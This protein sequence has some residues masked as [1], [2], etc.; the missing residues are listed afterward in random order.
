MNKAKIAVVGG[1]VAGSTAALYL[2]EIG[3]NVTLFEKGRSLI[4]G[5][6]FCHLHAGGNLY[7][8]I[9][10]EQCITLLGQSIDLLR[11][12]PYSVDFRPTVIAVPVEDSSTPQALFPRLEKLK[13]AYERLISA[14]P[15][16][17]VLGDSSDY[18]KVYDRKRIER[19]KK[20]H[21]PPKPASFDEWMIPVAKNID[22]DKVQFPLIM[23]QEYGLNLFRMAATISLLLEEIG[24]CQ[25]R[26]DTEVVNIASESDTG[27]WRVRYLQEG[28]KEEECFDYLINAAG[29]RTGMIDD[30]LG[31]TRQRM[32]E[33]KAAYVTK[34]DACEG[35]WP[36][37][38]FYGERGTPQGMGQFTPYP[39]G[40]FQLHGMTKSITLF[41]NGLVKST[42]E[43]AQPRLTK[44]FMEKIDRNWKF[45]EA[46]QRSRSA[47]K[48]LSRFIPAFEKGKV[49]SKPLYGAQQIPGMDPSLRAADVS[50]ESDHYARCEIIKASSVLSM[51][52]QIMQRLVKLGY[53]EESLYGK[54]DFPHLDTLSERQVDAYAE[55]ICEERD[56]PLSLAYRNVPH[57]IGNS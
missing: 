2:G 11:F 4:S 44:H 33:F 36:E 29:F 45:T 30:M 46:A 41:D 47:V 42:G 55:R 50:F 37:V 54:R 56:Y 51:M 20:M 15:G 16:N 40:Y 21:I 48:H 49:A 5:P 9:S 32:V 22:L 26:T 19:L 12:Y 28:R 24:T 43:S 38:V 53:A 17:K 35:I 14:D 39:N 13:E 27:R 57:V 1:G 10:D 6:P 52:D 7:R 34:W 18:Y 23:V 31:F 3:L 25:V 8:E